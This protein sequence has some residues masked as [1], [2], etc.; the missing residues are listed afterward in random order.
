M[1]TIQRP[2]ERAATAL[3]AEEPGG[4][5]SWLTT[6]DHKKIGIMYLVVSFFF[7]KQHQVF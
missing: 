7:F 4:W 3:P 2:V 5:S 6:V 1:A